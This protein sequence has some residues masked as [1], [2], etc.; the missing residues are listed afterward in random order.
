MEKAGLTPDY[1]TGTSMSMLA[2][3]S[4][5]YP[6]DPAKTDPEGDHTKVPE[7][8]QRVYLLWQKTREIED[9]IFGALS[10]SPDDL[11][12]LINAEDRSR[13]FEEYQRVCGVK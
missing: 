8:R 9:V 13:D 6:A 1:V 11:N 10:F 7:D 5:S 12:D 3:G 4:T 2:Y